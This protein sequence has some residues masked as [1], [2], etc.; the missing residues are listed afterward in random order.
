MLFLVH[1]LHG[2]GS[3]T[4]ISFGWQE[5][6][7]QVARFADAALTKK[8]FIDAF[9]HQSKGNCIPQGSCLGRAG[10]GSYWLPTVCTAI[11]AAQ[12]TP[13]MSL[14]SGCTVQP[15]RSS[16]CGCA[17][18]LGGASSTNCS[19][20][21]AWS[22]SRVSRWAAHSTGKSAWPSGPGQASGSQ[23]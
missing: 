4:K 6:C 23:Q 2:H 1:T 5:I 22:D 14:H 16:R 21:P 17:S 19:G 11:D 8:S 3:C 20:L 13:A 15:L 12:E 9:Y 10:Q 18:Y 7:G